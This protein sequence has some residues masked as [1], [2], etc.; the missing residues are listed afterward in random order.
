[1]TPAGLLISSHCEPGY[2]PAA[3][4]APNHRRYARRFGFAEQ[5]V[6]VPVAGRHPSWGKVAALRDGLSAG[7]AWAF[8]LDADAVF[9]R[10]A[11]LREHL[12]ADA[13][14][15][16]TAPDPQADLAA[17]PSPISLGTFG[18]RNTPWALALLARLW[19]GVQEPMHPW[20]EQQVFHHLY[21]HDPDVRRRTAIAPTRLLNGH[22]LYPEHH[23]PESL[24]IHPAGGDPA[25]KASLLSDFD[26]RAGF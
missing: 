19:D 23:G 16:V 5:F 4:T 20:A 10:P 6:V 25:A 7:V 11:D 24:V 8:H 12:P 14:L 15:L 26:R 18:V 13:D 22:P 1:M 3:V 21:R 9:A 17:D 2:P